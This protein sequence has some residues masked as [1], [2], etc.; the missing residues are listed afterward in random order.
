[1][2]LL[3]DL[4]CHYCRKINYI[5]EGLEEGVNGCAPNCRV[6]RTARAYPP[7]QNL[8][9]IFGYIPRATPIKQSAQLVVCRNTFY[10]L[11][12]HGQKQQNHSCMQRY[13]NRQYQAAAAPQTT[14]IQSVELL[15]RGSLREKEFSQRN[16]T[17]EMHWQARI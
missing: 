5:P 14:P 9:D 11:N 3:R 7:A 2:C 1:M 6:L 10:Q 16:G 12:T 13:P 17:P 8:H 4:R 15:L